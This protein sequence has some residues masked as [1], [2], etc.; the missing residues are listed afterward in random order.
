M[1]FVVLCCGWVGEGDSWLPFSIDYVLL[2]L[3]TIME[4]IRIRCT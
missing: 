4:E 1:K 3:K 2:K